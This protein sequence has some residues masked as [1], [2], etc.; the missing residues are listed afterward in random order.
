MTDGTNVVPRC[1]GVGATAI[2]SVEHAAASAYSLCFLMPCALSLKLWTTAWLPQVLH[3][4]L[5]CA[6]W[7]NA[8]SY[9]MFIL[10][11]A[12]FS[13]RCIC[14]FSWTS[15]IN[16][17]PIPWTKLCFSFNQGFSNVNSFSFFQMFHM[18]TVLLPNL[19]LTC[20]SCNN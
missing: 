13:A 11:S 3:A 16:I 4:S 10:C 2:F 20:F 6:D 9:S 14:C 7:T 15:C 12:L 5:E 17:L 18:S 19:M 8:V 1:I